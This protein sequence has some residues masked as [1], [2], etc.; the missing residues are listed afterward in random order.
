MTRRRNGSLGGDD[1]TLIEIEQPE[2]SLSFRAMN[3]TKRAL[4]AAGHIGEVLFH[5][6]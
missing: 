5:P 4:V 3:E 1:S 2:G 6:K